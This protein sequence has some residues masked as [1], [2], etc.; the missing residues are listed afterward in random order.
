MRRNDSETSRGSNDRPPGYP[1]HDL[2]MFPGQGDPHHPGSP[3]GETELPYPAAAEGFPMVDEG[4]GYGPQ[5]AALLGAPYGPPG[6]PLAPH[7]D[8]IGPY[9]PEWYGPEGEMIMVHGHPGAYGPPPG[10][11]I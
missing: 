3:T 7:P 10:N 2:G 11:M 4:L 8:D 6:P 9:G 5:P 1:G